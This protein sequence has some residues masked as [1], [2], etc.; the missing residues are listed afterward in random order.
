MLP[1]VLEAFPTESPTPTPIPHPTSTP[2]P[3]A[4]TY[5]LLIATR[6]DDSLFVVNQTAQAFP[7]EPLRLENEDGA[8]DGAEWEIETLEPGACVAAWKD[9]GNPKRPDGLTCDPI[10][11]RLT[12]DGPDRF[13]DSEFDVY[14]AGER[15]QTCK[16]ERCSVSITTK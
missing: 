11:E 9:S 12:R 2:T 15:I 13:W 7:L 14:Y 16:D 8:I 1:V 3:P 4:I 5:N 10:G 6:D